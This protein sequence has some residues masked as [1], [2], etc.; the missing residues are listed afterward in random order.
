MLQGRMAQTEE[1]LTDLIAGLAP[2]LTPV[3]DALVDEPS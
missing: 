1:T 2:W 3:S